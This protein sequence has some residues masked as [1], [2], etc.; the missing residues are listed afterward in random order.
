LPIRPAWPRASTAGAAARSAPC[1]RAAL[2]ALDAIQPSLLAALAKAPDP[3]KALARWERLITSLPS[4]VNLFRLLEARP[5][6]L[7]VMVRI[8]ALAPPLADELARRA[9]L[10]DTLIDASALN[11]PGGVEAL[12]ADFPPARRATIT[13]ASSTACAARWASGALPLA[14]N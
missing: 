8:L 12:I 10:L 2:A 7:Q 11:L 14:C 3:D 6:L 4:A 5:A 1:A 13:S 9:D